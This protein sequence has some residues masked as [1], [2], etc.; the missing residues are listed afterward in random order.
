MLRVDRFVII[1][2]RPLLRS[3][4]YEKK[5]A[6][7]FGFRATEQATH[8]LKK[9]TLGT[10]LDRPFFS[11]TLYYGIALAHSGAKLVG[12]GEKGMIR[13]RVEAGQ[14]EAEQEHTEARESRG[15]RKRW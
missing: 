13:T 12:G 6:S 7:G 2:L 5:S 15:E 8:R 11:A 1:A 9:R 3:A 14:E 10:P 4:S